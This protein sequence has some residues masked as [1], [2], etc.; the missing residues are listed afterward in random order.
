MTS[1]AANPIDE[2]EMGKS[3]YKNR[4]VR[5]SKKSRDESHAE[6]S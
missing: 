6:N 3:N 1:V 4:D 5:A 2:E